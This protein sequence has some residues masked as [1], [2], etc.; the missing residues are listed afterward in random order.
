LPFRMNFQS[1]SSIVAPGAQDRDE[2]IRSQW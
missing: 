1:R 2:L